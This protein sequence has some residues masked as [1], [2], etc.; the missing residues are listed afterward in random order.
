MI[1]LRPFRAWRPAPDKAHLVASRSYVSYTDEK[2]REKLEGNPYSFLHVIHAD[3]DRAAHLP[4][5]ERFL[6]VRRKWN[7]FVS[8]GYFI[9][10][11]HPCIYLYEQSRRGSMSRGIV[12]AISVADYRAGRVK[13]HEHTLQA[14]EELFKEYLQVTGINAEPVLLASP[15]TYGVDVALEAAWRSRPNYDFTTTDMVRHR[16]WAI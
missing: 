5:N 4:R 6:Q 10:D 12:A 8:E 14:R 1:R 16:L 15:E 11:E 3:L 7:D 9:R 13:V 2:I